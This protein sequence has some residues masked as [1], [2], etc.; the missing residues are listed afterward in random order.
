MSN[1]AWIKAAPAH[2]TRV[3][4]PSPSLPVIKGYRG[5]YLVEIVEIQM[6]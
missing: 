4:K 1:P 6:E 3:D 5:L 2:Q